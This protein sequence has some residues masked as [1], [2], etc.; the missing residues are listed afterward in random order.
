MNSLM[1]KSKYTFDEI[2]T[3]LSKVPSSE[4]TLAQLA[5]CGDKKECIQDVLSGWLV[6]YK[7]EKT[8]EAA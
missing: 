7:R 4:I 5:K 2:I 1:K 8:K 3:C 6:D